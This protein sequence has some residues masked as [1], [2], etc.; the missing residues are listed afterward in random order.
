MSDQD[1]PVEA[2]END[3]VADYQM[4]LM[5]HL[6]ELRNRLIVSIVS[7]VFCMCVAFTMAPQI[8]A[9][10]STPMTQA[11]EAQ[12]HGMMAITSPI[13]GIVTY[14][15][16]A[17][18]TGLFISAPVVFYQFWAFV[19]PGL[20]PPE[21]K[22]VLPL[23]F[24]STALFL[25]GA[26]FGYAVIFRYAFPFFL[27]IVEGHAESVISISAYLSTATRMLFAFGLCFQLPVIAYFLSRIG[28]ID[29]KDMRTGFKYAIVGMFVV[30]ALITPPDIMTQ[31]LMAGPLISLYGVG[32]LVA[33]LTSTKKRDDDA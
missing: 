25:L 23:V 32:M 33:K 21:Q 8:W 20:Y 19:A 26:V 6:R 13:E 29:A 18:I 10:L 1:P 9:F 16:V 28:L 30:S 22:T 11:I 4:P 17:F 27:A 14:L 5:D 3:P 12:G 7:I 24:A 31:I 15:R 2:S